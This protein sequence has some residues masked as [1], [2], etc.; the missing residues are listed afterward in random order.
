MRLH[1]DEWFTSPHQLTARQTP[2]EE[3]RMSEDGSLKGFLEGSNNDLIG[4]LGT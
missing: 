4:V 1:E 3:A 2:T